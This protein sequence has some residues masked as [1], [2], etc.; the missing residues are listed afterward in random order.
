MLIKQRLFLKAGLRYKQ[1]N[2]Q[3]LTR[4]KIERFTQKENIF[5]NKIFIFHRE[6]LV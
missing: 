1:T 4:R 5:L 3:Q 6:S 2:L